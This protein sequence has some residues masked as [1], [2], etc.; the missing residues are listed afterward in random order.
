MNQKVIYTAL[1]GGYDTL[2]QPLV[3]Q[4]GWDYV[5]FTDRDGKEGVWQLRKVPFGGSP[6]L[7]AR[8][9]KLQPHRVLPEYEISV[10]M[11][12][13]LCIAQDTFYTLVEKAL[14]EGC[15]LAGVPHPSRDCVFDE[16]VKCYESGR[17]EYS[18][19]KSEH[20]FGISLLCV[21][22]PALQ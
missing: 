22:E 6:V 13:N 9:V 7:Q 2:R 17:M 8:Q 21:P 3:V 10:W 16:L 20:R 19:D 11:D 14:D 5:C 18:K 12:A 15:V 4:E 1:T